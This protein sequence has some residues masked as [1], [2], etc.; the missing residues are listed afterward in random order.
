MNATFYPQS[1]DSLVERF[2]W[3]LLD[4]L[5][6]T[7]KPGTDCDERLLCVL[8]AYRATIQA[9]AE[10]SPFFLYG[11]DPQLPIDAALF[12]PVEQFTIDKDDYCLHIVQ[13][14]NKAWEL[15]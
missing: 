9:S 11:R 14:M 15:A 10:K 1:D 13:G 6:Q 8:F 7:V 3:T 12:P 5:A 4:M 2:N